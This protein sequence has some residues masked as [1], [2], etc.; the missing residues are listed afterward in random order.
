LCGGVK[1]SSRKICLDISQFSVEDE[2]NRLSIIKL[3]PAVCQQA[4]VK[5][6]QNRYSED[7]DT[8]SFFTDSLILG[9]IEAAPLVL[10]TVGF[11]LIFYL[12]GFINVAYAETITLGA[13]FAIVFNS[14]LG[15]NFYLAIIPSALLSGVISVGTYLVVFRPAF[16]RGVGSTEMI[17]LS[18]GLS[19]FIRYSLRLIFGSHLYAL[20]IVSPT[21]FRIFGIGI[22]NIQLTALILVAVITA[23]LYLFIY[24]TNYGEMMRGLAN[25]EDLAMVSGINP[26]RVSVLIWFIAGVAGGLAGLFYGVFSFVNTLLGW[27]LIL[28]IIMITIVGGIGNV[29]GALIASIGAGIITAAVTLIT[30]PL[31]GEVILL[32]SFIGILRLKKVR[33]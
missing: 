15:L 33:R 12:S 16:K 21:S 30:K 13:Y 26:V 27:R 5:N 22:T 14:M 11:T 17:I 3:K 23:G 9:I 24:R 2:Q 25:N 19:F 18:V 8:M 7:G 32:L 29:R 28:I 10:A 6:Q 20:D 31:Y 1:K 4:E